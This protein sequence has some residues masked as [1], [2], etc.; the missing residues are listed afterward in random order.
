MKQFIN[1]ENGKVIFAVN[2]LQNSTLHEEWYDIIIFHI[3]ISC[4]K[5]ISQNLPPVD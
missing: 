2:H 3:N 5:K 4:F 1:I